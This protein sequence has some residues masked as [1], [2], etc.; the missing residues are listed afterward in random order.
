VVVVSS[1]STRDQTVTVSLSIGCLFIRSRL[2]PLNNEAWPVDIES[3]TVREGMA[4]GCSLIG[5]VPD[6][7]ILLDETSERKSNNCAGGE[8]VV[9][10]DLRRIARRPGN[11]CHFVTKGVGICVIS[12]EA[13]GTGDRCELATFASG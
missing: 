5:Y 2:P 6:N 9:F 8:N 3:A 7:E 1:D 4:I 11:P 12:Q 13:A 10:A